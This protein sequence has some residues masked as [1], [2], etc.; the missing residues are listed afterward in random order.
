MPC[1]SRPARKVPPKAGPSRRPALAGAGVGVRS[2]LGSSWAAI[3]WDSVRCTPSE[4]HKRPRFT[5]GLTPWDVHRR[6]RTGVYRTEFGHQ[7][8]REASWLANSSE[9]GVIYR[10]SGCGDRI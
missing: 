3:L 7:T 10:E 5:N 9:A 1:D 2:R 4:V 8:S 6:S